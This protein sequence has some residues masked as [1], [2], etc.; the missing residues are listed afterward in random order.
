MKLTPTQ[1]RLLDTLAE[2]SMDWGL[3]REWG[4]S[5]KAAQA[6]VKFKEARAKFETY[7]KGQNRRLVKSGK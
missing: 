1:V 2:A 7:L 4:S 6:E 5:E 3:L